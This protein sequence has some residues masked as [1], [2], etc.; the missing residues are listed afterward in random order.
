MSAA[1]RK[2]RWAILPLA[3]I[4][5]LLAG[6]SPLSSADDDY[7]IFIDGKEVQ[8]KVP[9]VVKGRYLL[10]PGDVAVK[11]GVSIK[12]SKKKM[13]LVHGNILVE[14]KND[15]GKKGGDVLDGVPR[16]PRRVLQENFNIKVDWDRVDE[17]VEIST[18]DEFNPHM[19]L[20]APLTIAMPQ[21]LIPDFSLPDLDGEMVALS[22]FMGKRVVL[23]VFASWDQSRY[24]LKHWQ[25]FQEEA[26]DRLQVVGVAIEAEG[27]K[28]VQRYVKRAQAK[29]PILIDQG[30]LLGRL[31]GFNNVPVVIV[32]DELG[33][34]V[35]LIPKY[36]TPKK[37]SRS[38]KGFLKAEIRREYIAG[39][40]PS[41][42]LGK[43]A[44][45]RAL[46]EA[47]HDIG[48][49]FRMAEIFRSEGAL[50]K[51]ILE[52]E[53]A[54]RAAKHKNAEVLFRWGYYLW[55]Q[56]TTKEAKE[57]WKKAAGLAP[58]NWMIRKQIWALRYP[59]RFYD[60][61]IDLQWQ[62]TMISKGE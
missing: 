1:V 42:V 52:M 22:S 6:P 41:P 53:S 32:A 48:L 24:H 45:I 34:Y 57:K 44:V 62:Q 16:I 28:R 54:D 59:E 11:V 19:E 14:I 36:T 38:L 31:F 37:A 2:S 51:S 7:K 26:G 35:R 50:K 3:A 61:P 43:R 56:E 4:A 55:L 33:A 30:N 46:G 12:W 47:P 18:K 21:A 39:R 8:P 29:F 40:D 60:G 15:G 27:D 5:L 49:R 17:K 58:N 10:I 25:K 20:P 13:T 23:V 9:V